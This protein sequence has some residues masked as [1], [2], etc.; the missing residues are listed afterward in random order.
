MMPVAELQAASKIYRQGEREI[1]ALRDVSLQIQQGEFAAVL[2][3][4]GSGKSTLIHLLGCLDRPSSGRVLFRER[5]LGQLSDAQL[6]SLR[7][8]SI[9]FVFQTFYLLSRYRALENVMLPLLYR[10][11]SRSERRVL[12]EQALLR[13]G[14]EPRMTHRPS[15]LSGGECQRV[16][17]ARAIVNQPDLLLADEPTGNLDR[18]TGL[19][20]I[21]LFSRLNQE[22]GTTVVLVTHDENLA[23]FSHRRFLLQ[24]G[25]IQAE[26]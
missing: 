26:N 6:A 12:A 20:I 1:S 25:A 19:E 22:M 9:G 11:L 10:G 21:E 3:P 2:G 24:D 15:E 7:N 17:I 16:A 23:A 4:S 13:V 5:D 8:R 14:L 18:K